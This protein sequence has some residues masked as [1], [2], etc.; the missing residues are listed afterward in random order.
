MIGRRHFV[1]WGALGLG[2]FAID[3]CGPA[4]PW[5]K[6]P[7]QAEDVEH[8]LRHL[9]EIVL[10]LKSLE[11][12]TRRFGIKPDASFVAQGS[13]T[14]KRL[15]TALCVLGI[16]RDVPQALW[17]QPAVAQRLAD[18]LP[19]THETLRLA[20]TYL[21]GMT[22]DVGTLIENKLKDDPDATM[23]IMERV[24]EYARQ[25]QVPIELRTYLRTATA[26]LAG[27]FRYE[28][29]KEVTSKLV[30][31]W[32]RA[33][34]T[35]R[36]ELGMQA[37]PGE[38]G[39]SPQ[40]APPPAP[41]RVRF[42]TPASPGEVHVATCALEPKITIDGVD[43]QIL[44]D[45]E[46]SRCPASSTIKLSDEQPPIHGAV[47]IEPGADQNVVT[48]VIYPP[49][50]VNEDALTKGAT[51]IAR[52]LQSV[53]SV[54]TA[55]ATPPPPAPAQR[56]G[57]EGE[58][59]RVKSD[60]EDTLSCSRGTCQA[61]EDAPSSERLIKT[62]KEVAKWGAYLSIPPICAI[63]ALVLLTCLFMVIVAGLLYAGGD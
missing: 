50:D 21:A 5:G 16:V 36:A 6:G 56:A 8:M 26:Q 43:R 23:R 10:Q 12:D 9:D 61:E 33:A 45:W 51:D 32:D 48:L 19:K 22:D 35:R 63:G 39:Q 14:C 30:S 42:R 60:C 52:H 38:G 25:V 47:H 18:L 20:R 31:K 55:V 27:R 7:M 3:G 34:A 11:P 28:G 24:D 2:A 59:C 37:D 49:P 29:A 17:Q 1:G 41:I 4:L 53:L 40:P 54:R 62:T 15:L 46:E 57:E 44:L 58:S 13:A